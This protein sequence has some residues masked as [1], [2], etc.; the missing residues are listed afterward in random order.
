MGACLHLIHHPPD[1]SVSLVTNE[2]DE[3]RASFHPFTSFTPIF[4]STS[5]EQ[6][7]HI[8]TGKFGRLRDPVTFD[9]PCQMIGQ[10]Y[11]PVITREY[12]LALLPWTG[13]ALCFASHLCASHF[14]CLLTFL[15]PAHITWPDRNS[16]P[17]SLMQ[18]ATTDQHHPMPCDFCGMYHPPLNLLEPAHTRAHLGV[19]TTHL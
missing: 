13:A 8:R 12:Y 18:L 19:G 10:H 2:D 4:I 3:R 14:S 16:A 7:G 9:E 5:L 17:H 11:L 15:G 1:I 6:T